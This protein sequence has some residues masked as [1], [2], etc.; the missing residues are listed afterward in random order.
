MIPA[1]LR[2]L[3][4]VEAGQTMMARVEGQQL[5]LEP[6]EAA[7]ARLR[8]RVGSLGTDG[9]MVNELIGERRREA[10]HETER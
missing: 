3:L 5:I 4:G 10:R 1:A 7:L 8:A 2:R 9:D 6:R